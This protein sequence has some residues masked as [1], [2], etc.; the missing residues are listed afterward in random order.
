MVPRNS[1]TKV[2]ADA[3]L[4]YHETGILQFVQAGWTLAAYAAVVFSLTM[5][6]A[7]VFFVSLFFFRLYCRQRSTHLVGTRERETLAGSWSA[8]TWTR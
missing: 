3:A 6:F 8:S 1:R 5:Y 2:H 7:R 4:F